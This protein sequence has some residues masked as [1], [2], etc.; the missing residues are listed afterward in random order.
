[1]RNLKASEQSAKRN[2]TVMRTIQK[3]SVSERARPCDL[4]RASLSILRAKNSNNRRAEVY[5]QVQTWKQARKGA[6]M[7]TIQKVESEIMLCHRD[8]VAKE[9]SLVVWDYFFRPFGS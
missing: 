6:I 5:N 8:E 1:M 4:E 3:A 2:V 9:N 7:R